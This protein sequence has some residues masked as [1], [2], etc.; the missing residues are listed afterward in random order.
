MYFRVTG[1]DYSTNRATAVLTAHRIEWKAAYASL[2]VDFGMTDN[3]RGD[4]YTLP[5][6]RLHDSIPLRFGRRQAFASTG[7]Q[8]ASS[9]TGQVATSS[10]IAYP[11]APTSTPSSESSVQEVTFAYVDQ[12][13]IISWNEM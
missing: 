6:I 13:S 4:R 11:S 5:G 10:T 1:V 7:G 2:K 9:T 8:A 12:P 3:S